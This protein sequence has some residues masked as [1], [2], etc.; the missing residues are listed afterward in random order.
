[1][2]SRLAPAL[3]GSVEEEI[4]GAV[5]G[6]RIQ[7]KSQRPIRPFT[8]EDRLES[9]PV[10]LI[11][12]SCQPTEGLRVCSSKVTVAVHDGKTFK[13]DWCAANDRLRSNEV[14]RDDAHVVDE[15]LPFWVR[16]QASI[17]FFA[18]AMDAS[19][20]EH[21][22]ETEFGQAPNFELRTSIGVRDRVIKHIGLLGQIE[23]I[24]GGIGGRLYGECLGTALAIHLLRQYG[25]SPKARVIYKGGLASR[26]LQRVID[27]INDHLQDELS[28]VDLARAAKLSPQ[29]FVT[30][31][32]AST[33]ISP[34]QYVINRRI[35]R[36]RDMLR[37]EDKTISEIAYAV[38]F[39]SQSHLTASFRRTTG[40]TPRKFRQSLD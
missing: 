33:G 39:S 26:P 17:S 20:V 11:R 9:G 27:Y 1:M 18:I 15:R 24:E 38:G 34:H 5:N 22:W 23:L 28:I 36:A 6:L 40:L 37:R 3:N 32:K 21:I 8:V 14:V 16:S 25:T 35:D 2:G 10:T 7:L 4:I 31:F 19:F 30:A 13:M 12:G 29:H